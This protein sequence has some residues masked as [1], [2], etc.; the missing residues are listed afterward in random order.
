MQLL[1]VVLQLEDWQLKGKIMSVIQVDTFAGKLKK[2]DDAI[3]LCQQLLGTLNDADSMWSKGLKQDSVLDPSVVDTSFLTTATTGLVARVDSHMLTFSDI[4]DDV[5]DLIGQAADAPNPIN[6]SAP[7]VATA[8][9]PWQVRAFTL[10][11]ATNV[12]TATEANDNL[13]LKAETGASP[14]P[15]DEYEGP[16]SGF[17][18]GDIVLLEK[19]E[20]S[21]NNGLYEIDTVN[22]TTV[23]SGDQGQGAGIPILAAGLTFTSNNV[24]TTT[25]TFDTKVVITLVQKAV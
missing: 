15:P 2:L 16:F 3:S 19:C 22:A 7:L 24:I 20:D 11:N 10:S 13:F 21:E 18:P 4:K 6:F 5:L 25:N 17:S 23:W 1:Q 8:G 14:P 9:K 12:I